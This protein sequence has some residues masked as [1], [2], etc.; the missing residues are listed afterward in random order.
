M[1]LSLSNTMRNSRRLI[2]MLRYQQLLMEMSICLN[3]IQFSDIFTKREIAL[4][5]G[6]Q[7]V[8]EREQK[9][10]STWTGITT[11]SDLELEVISSENICHLLQ[12]NLLQKSL[13]KK[14]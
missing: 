6:T 11:G 9:L 13:F 1:S 3:L 4:I 5:I 7:L 8:L 14:A 12:E 10:M 2:L